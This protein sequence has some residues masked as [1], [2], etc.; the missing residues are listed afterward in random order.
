MGILAA[1]AGAQGQAQQAARLIGAAEGLLEAIGIPFSGDSSSPH[2]RCVTTTRAALG[3]E[4]F[5]AARVA[6]RAMTL[7]QAIQYAQEEAAGD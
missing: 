3:D 5:A 6:G 1:V 7:D 2:E 4:A